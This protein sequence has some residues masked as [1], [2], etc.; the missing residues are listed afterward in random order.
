MADKRVNVSFGNDELEFI[1]NVA[2]ETFGDKHR[3]RSDVVRLLVRRAM[4]NEKRD[5]K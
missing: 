3:R 5:K 1:D 2:N 4:S